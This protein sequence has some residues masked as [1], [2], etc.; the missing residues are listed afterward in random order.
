VLERHKVLASWQRFQG[1]NAGQEPFW[2]KKRAF[3]QLLW[4]GNDRA[5]VGGYE[6]LE[7]RWRARRYLIPRIC[8]TGYNFKWMERGSPGRWAWRAVVCR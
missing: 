1:L 8:A 6:V 3:V 5:R 2:Y 4:Q 7:N